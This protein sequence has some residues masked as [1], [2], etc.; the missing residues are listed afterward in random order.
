MLK[1]KAFLHTWGA[2]QAV[3]LV[4]IDQVDAAPLV[5][6]RVAVALVDLLAADGT[7]VARI[8]DTRVGVDAI[9]AF[10]VVARIR[11]TVVDILLTQKASKTW[12][13]TTS[14]SKEGVNW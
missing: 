2:Q 9:L 10:P 7:H 12:G 8:A 1:S 4:A 6:A 14:R 11:I 5:E 13:K 3:A